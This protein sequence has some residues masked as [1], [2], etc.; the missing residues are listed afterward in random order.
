[1]PDIPAEA[2]RL[3]PERVIE[4]A[5]GLYDGP[6]TGKDAP[7][8]MAKAVLAE[9][10][11]Q[12]LAVVPAAHANEHASSHGGEQADLRHRYAD[13]IDRVLE[14]PN[15]WA[16]RGTLPDALLAVRDD[17]LAEA[18]RRAAQAD[19]ALIAEVARTCGADLDAP[20]THKELPNVAALALDAAR[21]LRADYEQ[22]VA[23]LDHAEAGLA[24]VRDL[25]ARLGVTDPGLQAEILTALDG[26]GAVPEEKRDPRADALTRFR[27]WVDT[28]FRQ[29]CS[30]DGIAA[31]YATNLIEHLDRLVTEEQIRGG[32]G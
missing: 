18:R 17:E 19:A 10:A 5:I 26:A 7:P 21:D 30:P 24:R 12:G 25:A 31:R 13:A 22:A 4:V 8:T 15:G 2:A 28:D 14:Q 20:R 27:A 16:Y 1:M 29:W 6:R 9:L 32:R 23:Q 11:E 3:S